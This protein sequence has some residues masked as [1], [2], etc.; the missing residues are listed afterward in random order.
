MASKNSI[1]EG[2]IAGSL[3]SF[4]FPIWLG[5][6]FQQLYNTADAVIVGNFVGKEALAAVG[7]PTST[8][9]N[10]L[11]GFFVGMSSGAGVVVAQM[12]GG[13]HHDDTH[14]AVHTSMALALVGGCVM[15]AIGLSSSGFL[16]QITGVPQEIMAHSKVYLSCFFF[17]SV[18]NVVYNIGAAILRAMGD[19][20]RP[21][22]F[23]LI[24]SFTNIVLDL[25]F[26]VVL[27]K[28]VL[29][30]GV[31][32]LI[33]QIIS[34]L[35]VVH[36]LCRMHP[37]YALHFR[38]I[39]FDARITRRIFLIGIPAGLQSVLYST[40]NI[41]IQSGINWFGT[42]TIA[43]WTAYSKIDQFFWMTINSYGIAITT[44]AG[45]N[46][47][48]GN[49]DRMR[50]S[51]RICMWMTGITCVVMSAGM[52]L[53]AEPLYRVFTQDSAVIEIGLVMMW[54][55]TP[56]YITYIAVE[57]LCGALR[58]TGDS[59]VPTLMT[60]FG[61]CVLRLFWVFFVMPQYRSLEVLCIA[62]P[63]TWM[64]TSAMF[65]VYYCKGKWLSRQIGK[66]RAIPVEV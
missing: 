18:F 47:G 62:Y 8:I 64:V 17:G 38:S 31:A 14:K 7:G 5:T 51:V 49:Y 60:C 15:M 42:N 45:Q 2:S 56:Y 28:G 6:F 46:F 58:A 1:T 53:F 32:T 44:F 10:L 9:I 37:V 20:R 3:L 59:L 19:A 13:G 66:T 25:L 33:S 30:V 23:L 48:A 11:L 26:V 54:H 63:I 22:Y 36:S 61:I 41:V 29:G 24:C 21:L 12:Y 50:K 39:R 27:K 57:I 52:L 43:A 4:F 55:M 35:L 40:S 34:A 16:L 65:I